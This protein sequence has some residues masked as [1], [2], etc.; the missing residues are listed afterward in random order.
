MLPWK[1]VML[2]W[3]QVMLP[4]KQVMLPWNNVVDGRYVCKSYCGFHVTQ[5]LHNLLIVLCINLTF[6]AGKLQTPTAVM[7][8]S[9]KL[10]FNTY[11]NILD[12]TSVRQMLNNFY[13][14][15]LYSWNLSK[16]MM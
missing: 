10:I 16:I 5:H 2:P 3:K 15:K 14:E 8:L 7:S 9:L 11:T 6:C 1:Q 13:R 4:W 12:R